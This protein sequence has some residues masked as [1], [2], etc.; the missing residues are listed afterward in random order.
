MIL[1]SADFQWSSVSNGVKFAFIRMKFRHKEK[2][3]EFDTP[4]VVD[5]RNIVTSSLRTDFMG[6]G[7]ENKW[8][9]QLTTDFIIVVCK[10]WNNQNQKMFEFYENNHHSGLKKLNDVS[11][12]ARGLS[13]DW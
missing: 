13:T 6:T 7:E 8:E 12:D 5:S 2:E 11:K 9:R 4:N 10:L 3:N 1:I